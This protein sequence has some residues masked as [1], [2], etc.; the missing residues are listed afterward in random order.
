MLAPALRVGWLLPARDLRAALVAAKRAATSA[1]P[2][3]PSSVLAGLIASGE[4]ERQLRLVRPRQRPRRDAMI[5][6]LRE[7]LPQA[8][9]HGAAAGLHLM[10]TS[11]AGRRPARRPPRRAARASTSTRCPGTARPG[12]PGLVLGYAAPRRTACAT[13]C[14]GWHRS[15]AEPFAGVTGLP[16]TRPGPRAYA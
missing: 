12:P 13:R 8:R 4:L 3:S 6:A 1:T 2:R 10:L 5:A 9:V 11:G 14:G 16:D 15:S 7:H